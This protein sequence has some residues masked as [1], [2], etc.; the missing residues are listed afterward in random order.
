[1]KKTSL[2][3]CLA[4]LIATF[5]AQA[6]E[7]NDSTTA[8]IQKLV[9]ALVPEHMGIGTPKANAIDVVEDSIKV[10]L[11]EN[12]GDVPFTRENINQLKND[13]KSTLGEQYQSNNVYITIASNSIENYFSDFETS[14]QRKHNAFIT[15]LDEN[16]HYSKGLDGNIVAVWP[17][18]GWYFEPYLN[19][20][21]W[22][23]ARLFHTV[24]DMYTHSYM[25]PF[26]MPMLENA[27]AY[28]WDARERDTHN[29][30]VVVDHDGGHAQKGYHENNG[31]KKW[32]NGEGKGFAYNRSEYKDFENPFEEGSYRM[33]EAES[34]RNKLA[35]ATWD[36]DM[37]EAGTFA[38]YVSYKSLPNSA[39][40]ATYTVNSLGGTQ[41]FVVDQ[42]MAG[43]VW[44][45][46]GSFQ[47]A[48]GMNK[49]VVSLSNHSSDSKAVITAD[50]IKVGGGKG[51]IVRRVALPTP[52]NIAIAE[53]ND[54]LKYLGKEGIDYQYVGSGDHPWFHLGARYFLQWSGFPHKVYSTSNG[55]NDYVDD[56]RSR[57]EW[58]NWL[59]G[60]SDVLPGKPGLKVP[61]DVSFC[62]HTDAGTTKND[63]IIGTLLIY[64]TTKNGKQFGKYEN[65]TPRELSRQFANIVSTEVVNDIRAKYEPNW[66]RRGMW[67]KSY[68]EARVPEVPALLMELLS[69]Q[70]YADMKYGLDPQFRFDVSRS[71][72]KGIAKFIA[73]RDHRECV[74][75]PLPVS[76]FAINKL[77]DN[78][79]MLNWEPT[80]DPLCSNA[81]AKKYIVLE[82]VGKGGFNEIDVVD[83]PHYSAYVTDNEIHSYKI[84]AMNDGGRSFPSETL[85]LGVAKHSKGTV[86][87]V[88][89][90]TRISA[91]D[92]FDSG[93]MAGFYDSKDHGVPYME[94]INYL[95]AQFEFRRNLEWRDDDAPGFGACRSNYET[96]NIAGNTFNYPSIHGK[97]I[98]E[99]GYS[100]VST[101][102]M[103][104][105]K[106]DVDLSSYCT[107]DMI[108]G[109]Q[110]ETP[111]GRGAKP[112][113]YKAFTTGLMNALTTYTRGGGNVLMTGAYVGS[114]IWDKEKSLGNEKN[115]AQN[116]MGY[117]WVDGRAT[118]RGEVY[119]VPSV[120]KMSDGMG[121]LHFYDTLNSDFYAVE[122]PDAIKASDSK[123][124]TI[125]RYSENNIPAGIAS[126]RNGYKTVVLGFPF[127]TIKNENER[128][129]F[130][131]RVLNFFEKK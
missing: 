111:T 34:D 106:G 104:V 41:Q 47:L 61:V 20:W 35:H 37:P 18:H 92:W 91:P 127:E 110:K 97:A 78:L 38:I 120:L 87:V 123:G 77:S 89:N 70:N 81:E 115:F 109:K 105:D 112:S 54:D 44:V 10:D 71:I 36:V 26:I 80:P 113:R 129:E 25:I 55:I 119:S 76:A 53:K 62:L 59:A 67:D 27:G 29:F 32:K 19:R 68:Y 83:E 96:Q 23:R 48:K 24:E 4:A 11:S 84:I 13:I 33:V 118:L 73:K 9:Q 52:E 49:A 51:N 50:A 125:V 22:Q 56:Y 95:G 79:Y 66:T 5:G 31:K 122:S 82:Q 116:V 46:L 130:M 57:G 16:R 21:E 98:M 93:E 101:S 126:S 39:H 88:N 121:D 100:F 28:V 30:G 107:V 102:A 8:K 90:F 131:Q 2:L 1:M 60:G 3:A 40:D 17:S 45:Y 72:Y 103:A 63:D 74:I 128:N 99:A 14:Y 108:M 85:S 6:T 86:M 75:Q 43:G 117:T 114:D 94:Q 58:V 7:I 69:H 15:P 12:F 65:G 124:A 64:C 42:A